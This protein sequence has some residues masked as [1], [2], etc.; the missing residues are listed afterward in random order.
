M[1]EMSEVDKEKAKKFKMGIFGTKQGI[2]D[3]QE[4]EEEVLT[5]QLK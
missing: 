3:A 5:S 4:F 1:S 2:K